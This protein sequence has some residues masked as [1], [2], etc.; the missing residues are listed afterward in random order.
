MEGKDISLVT[1]GLTDT[2]MV[3]GKMFAPIIGSQ[4]HGALLKYIARPAKE[5]YAEVLIRE[6]VLTPWQAVNLKSIELQQSP[7]DKNYENEIVSA[8]EKRT[9]T[10]GRRQMANDFISGVAGQKLRLE[11]S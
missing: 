10:R 7:R 3:E 11:V 4:E 5:A 9:G 8:V 2:V 6:F 1:R